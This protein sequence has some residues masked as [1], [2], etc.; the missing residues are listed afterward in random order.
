[1]AHAEALRRLDACAAARQGYEEA[2]V[3]AAGWAEVELW[4]GDAAFAERWW[5]ELPRRHPRLRGLRSA[6]AAQVLP[7][8]VP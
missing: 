5:S 4:A 3:L 1:V 2:A 7:P 8:R 6:L